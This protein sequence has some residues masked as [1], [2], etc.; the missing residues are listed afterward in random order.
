MAGQLNETDIATLKSMVSIGRN[1][2]TFDRAFYEQDMR[3][4]SEFIAGANTYDDRIQF[5]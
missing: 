1:Q 4:L 5:L 2:D 3:S